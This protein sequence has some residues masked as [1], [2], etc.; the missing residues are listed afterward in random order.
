MIV[1][2]RS[3]RLQFVYVPIRKQGWLST[4][5][6]EQYRVALLVEAGA[7]QIDHPPQRRARYKPHPAGVVRISQRCGGGR[8]PAMV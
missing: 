8:S 5:V 6:H 2:K 4:S 7:N 3:Q 1:A